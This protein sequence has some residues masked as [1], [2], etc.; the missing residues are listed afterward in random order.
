M[1]GR[2]LQV[3]LNGADV[4]AFVV[5]RAGGLRVRVSTDDWERLNLF[6]GQRISVSLPGRGDTWLYLTET[7][8]APPFVWA[9]MARRVGTAG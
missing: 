9:V 7:G 5:G 8:E 3:G 6:R 2:S 1:A 4:W